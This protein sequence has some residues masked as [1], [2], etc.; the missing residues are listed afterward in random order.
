MKYV[1]S[2]NESS[3]QRLYKYLGEP[4]SPIWANNIRDILDNKIIISNK[5]YLSNNID[6]KHLL[7]ID[8]LFSTFGLNKHVLYEDIK[9][10]TNSR[11]GNCWFFYSDIN[12]MKKNAPEFDICVQTF[13][14]EWYLVNVNWKFTN[15][16]Y[17]CDQFDGLE[18]FTQSLKILY[19]R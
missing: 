17:L 10:V 4:N 13:E 5:P 14:D 11:F 12:R 18:Q 19:N 6:K 8:N 7:E 2:F 15:N 9:D 1:R 16:W 3:S